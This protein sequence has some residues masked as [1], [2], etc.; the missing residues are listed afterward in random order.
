[1]VNG[2][3]VHRGFA[4]GGEAAAAALQ[5]HIG[6][7]LDEYLNVVSPPLKRSHELLCGVERDLRHTG[8]AR[9]H[10]GGVDA[11][12][13]S[14]NQERRL[15]RIADDLPVLHP[16]VIAGDERPQEGR[17]VDGS[18]RSALT[19]NCAFCPV[20]LTRYAKVLPAVVEGL[21]G[22]LVERQ[23]PRLVGADDSRAAESLDA[24]QTLHDRVLARHLAHPERDIQSWLMPGVRG[25]ALSR[26]SP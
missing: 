1:M 16:A 2:S 9:D 25:K 11:S 26:I 14:Q 17:K 23:G 8:E 21:R 22:H 20:T 18:G 7:A 4:V 10:G 15:G 19:A 24:R 3:A 5:K 12:L 13:G 6:R